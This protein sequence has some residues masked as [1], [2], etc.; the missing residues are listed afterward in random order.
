MNRS[1]T[2]ANKEADAD[3]ETL[4]VAWVNADAGN[5]HPETW[6][7]V[8]VHW[9]RPLHV[10]ASHRRYADIDISYDFSLCRVYDPIILHGYE[11]AFPH[12]ANEDVGENGMRPTREVLVQNVWHEDNRGRALRSIREMTAAP[13]NDSPVDEAGGEASDEAGG[14]V[15]DE[16]GDEGNYAHVG[17]GT[18]RAWTRRFESGTTERHQD[19]SA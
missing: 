14:E 5:A 6:E 16:E 2:E 1:N 17:E 9:A 10:L 11:G 13:R 18:E 7:P 4:Q 12:S 19:K 3:P 15:D 8:P